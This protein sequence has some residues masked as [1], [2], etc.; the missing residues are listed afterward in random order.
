MARERGGGAPPLRASAERDRSATKGFSL[1]PHTPVLLRARPPLLHQG[2]GA[3]RRHTLTR[4]CWVWPSKNSQQS[5]PEAARPPQS[6]TLVNPLDP[7]APHASS[8]AS[9]ASGAPSV[10][11]VESLT[12]RN[13]G[14]AQGG[15]RDHTGNAAKPIGGI[16]TETPPTIFLPSLPIRLRDCSSGCL[17]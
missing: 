15:T 17:L 12:K 11:A 14:W 2:P 5:L 8:P 13:F 6:P 9:R 16:G 7:A 4:P 3:R 1:P 10:P